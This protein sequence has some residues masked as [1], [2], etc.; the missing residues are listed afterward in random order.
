MRSVERCL[1]GPR[2]YRG[3]D[4]ATPEAS[5]DTVVDTLGLAPAGIEALE[6]VTLVTGEAL[7]ACEKSQVSTSAVPITSCCRH[8]FSPRSFILV[9][10]V[11]AVRQ[12]LA[13][14]PRMVEDIV[15]FSIFS[16]S[17]R[18]QGEHCRRALTLTAE[19]I[20]SSE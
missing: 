4:H 13:I 9:S 16:S 3:H 20:T 12:V 6:P 11:A 5:P 10:P 15:V 8:L 19:G 1:E 2:T 17:Y 18:L 14:A 7:R